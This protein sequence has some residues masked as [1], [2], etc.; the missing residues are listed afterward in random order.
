[1]PMNVITIMVDDLGLGDVSSFGATDI[2]TPNLDR[3]FARGAR[4]ANWRSNAPVCSPSRASLLT[5]RYPAAAGVPDNVP[6]DGRGLAPD[7][8]TLAELLKAHGYRTYL[9]GKWHCGADDSRDF[10][11][12]RGFDRTMGWR[13]GCLDYWSH[14]FYWGMGNRFG[15]RHDLWIDGARHR[16]FG[17]YLDT[18]IAE[19]AMAWLDNAAAHDAPFYLHVGFHAPHYPLQAPERFHER[20]AHLDPARAIYA[21]VILAFDEELGRLLDHLAAL[22]L[23]DDTIVVF[24]GDHG[25][26]R[27]PRNWPD[28]RDEPFPGG[29]T[30]G[31]RG[32]KFSCF[33]GGIHIPASIAIPGVTPTGAVCEAFGTGMDFVPTVM[34]ALDLPLEA[35][36]DGVDFL[37]ALRDA[38]ANPHAGEALVWRCGRQWAV[39]RDDW[40]LVIGAEEEPWLVDLASDRAEAINRAGERPAL[41]RELETAGRAIEPAWWE[42][43]E[44]PGT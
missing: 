10:P 18:L 23:D 15:P 34:A 39:R 40:K 28:H 38:T 19:Q 44:G 14:T 2:A 32:A 20:V 33:E 5:G 9:S 21:A 17:T 43:W 11:E 42:V 26:S 25:P 29:S 6:P 31:L 12:A 8:P 3:L 36:V 7:A 1:M 22:D 13:H 4:L 27:E 24:Q 35:E 16:R 41:V 37:P 30:L